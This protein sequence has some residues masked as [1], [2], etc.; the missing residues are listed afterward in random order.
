ME[1]LY[2]ILEVSSSATDVEI[3]KA[4]RKLALKYHPDKASEE[5]REENEI[6]FK[7]VSFAYE[8]LIDEE[9]RQHYDLYGTTD[10]NTGPNPYEFNGN[11][12]EQ[13]YG[14]GNYNGYEGNDFYDFFNGMNGN[15]SNQH[16]SRRTE[17]A[18][19][20]VEVTLE[21]L[22]IG[23]VIRSTST[24][25]IIC[26]QCKGSGV[27]SASA[28]SKTCGI[29]HGEGY[30]RKI[31]RVAPGLVAQEYVDCTTCNTSGKIY[32]TKDRCKLCK[33]TRVCEE[34]K[35]LEFEIPKGSPSEGSVVK[36][37]ESDE[38]PGKIAGD[39]ILKYTCKKHDV[40]ERKGDDLYMDLHIPLADALTGFS[41]LVTAH[42]DGRG[43]KVVT[44]KGKVIKPGDYIKL[45]GEGMP[46]LAEKRS[47]FSR[48]DGRGDLYIRV[49]I[50]FPTDNWYLEKN[51]LLTIKNILPTQLKANT[52]PP[53]SVPETNVELFT[54]FSIVSSSD[55][56][57]YNDMR[58]SNDHTHHEEGPQCTQQ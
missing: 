32:R 11:P 46:K 54:D 53:V 19:L 12:F 47:W 1:D 41:K 13:F 37:G 29:C 58:N 33:G 42:L 31:K 16:N 45:T 30:T 36:R 4:F 49:Q 57:D 38:Y 20:N 51:D 35:I 15:Q 23:K 17:D 6:H 21:D 43:V 5:D 10:G 52:T 9:K 8:I 28:V 14:G 22:Y 26:T 2:E 27:K 18:V 34:T 55:L 39:I 44:P 24:R 7:K 3:K 40:F 48:S 56:P 50:E 25:N